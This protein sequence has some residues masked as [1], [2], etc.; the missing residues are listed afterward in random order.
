MSK[1]PKLVRCKDCTEHVTYRPVG[2][3]PMTLYLKCVQFDMK[4]NENDGCTFG[5]LGD[6]LYSPR[7]EHYDIDLGADACVQ[8]E[9]VGEW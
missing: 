4:V 9:D 5:H 2:F 1:K 6:S 8:R 3:I 7:C